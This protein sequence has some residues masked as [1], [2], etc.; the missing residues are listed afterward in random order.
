VSERKTPARSRV[1]TTQIVMPSHMNAAGSLFGG[2][3][4]QWIDVCAAVSAMRH[5][6]G[7][8]VTA[9]IDR[10][11]FLSPIQLGDVVILQ[12]QVNYTSRTSME[13]GCRVETEDPISGT[14]RYTTKA[15]LTFVALDDRSRP[16]PVPALEPESADEQR[17]YEQAH[18]RRQERLRLAGRSTPPAES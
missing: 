8:V 16:R 10:L 9:S 15:Y 6:G 2:I 14:R 4:V 5:A 3:V 13:V 7:N 18:R 17:R 11:D 12:A 1:V